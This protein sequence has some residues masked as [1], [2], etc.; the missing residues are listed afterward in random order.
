MYENKVF[1]LT[2]HMHFFA[3]NTTVAKEVE[4]LSK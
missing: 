3:G 4:K 1:Y 2:K